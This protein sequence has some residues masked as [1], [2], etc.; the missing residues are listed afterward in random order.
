MNT[1]WKD[2]FKSLSIQHTLTLGGCGSS[3]CQTLLVELKIL[4]AI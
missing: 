3:T 1:R 4:V 2:A